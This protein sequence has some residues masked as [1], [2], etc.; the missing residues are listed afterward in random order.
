MIPDLL[1]AAFAESTLKKYRSSWSKW[2]SWCKQYDEVTYCPADPFYICIYF[3]DLI[4]EKHSINTISA[5][6]C[7]IRWGHLKAGYNSPTDCQL[8]K[9]AFKGAQRLANVERK[10]RKEPF[11]NEMIEQTVRRYGSSDNLIHLRFLVICVLGFAGFFRI[12]ELL[13]LQVSDLNFKEDWYEITIKKSKTDQ[14]REGNIVYISK[15]STS[16]YPVY[17]YE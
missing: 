3:N 9:L 13:D 6:L 14:T 10:N 1:D 11:T 7:G 16:T 12:S 15:T 2:M 5:A 8:V 4:M 17:W